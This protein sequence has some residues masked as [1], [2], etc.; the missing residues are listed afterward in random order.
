MRRIND[1]KAFEECPWKGKHYR[2]EEVMSDG[3][4]PACAHCVYPYYQEREEVLGK[5]RTKEDRKAEKKKCTPAE[6]E[7]N[8]VFNK[9]LR[10]SRT[11]VEIMF[12]NFQ[13]HRFMSGSGFSVETVSI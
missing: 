8:D 11:I 9:T 12:G 1:T 13:R 10:H 2:N 6:R 3:G 5:K 7:R 4:Y